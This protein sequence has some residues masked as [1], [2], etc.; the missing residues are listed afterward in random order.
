MRILVAEDERDLN[1]IITKRLEKAGYSVD[2]C[3]DG[4]EALDF[5]DAGEYDGVILDI[6]MPRRDGLSVVAA[7]RERKDHTPVLFLTARDTVEDK[8]TGLD[9][10]AEDYLVKPFAFDELLARIRVMTR[11]RAGHSTNV[12]TAAD[13]TLD[14]GRH[15]VTRGGKSID[16]SAKEFAILEYMLMNKG[17]VLSREKIENHIWN[18]DYAGGSNVI[19]VYIRYLRKKIDD[20]EQTKLIHTIRGKGYVLKEEF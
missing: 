15:T 14:A 10:G 20:G 3:F 18:F 7:M 11:K 5:L 1:R 6:M 19:D 12:L 16:L 8:V 2:S 9:A 17:L 13:L 4:E